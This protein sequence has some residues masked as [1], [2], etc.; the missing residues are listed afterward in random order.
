[1]DVLSEPLEA[2]QISDYCCTR[3]ILW[4]FLLSVTCTTN[5][6]II[7]GFFKRST[8]QQFEQLLRPHLSHLYK[9]A[10]RLACSTEDAED[11]IQD[12]LI[13]LYPRTE[14]LSQIESL[15][16]WLSKILYRQFV[17][18]WRKLSRVPES[19]STSE[20]Q[21]HSVYDGL[22]NGTGEPLKSLTHNQLKKNLN[23]AL[24]QLNHEQRS[25]ICMHLMDN[26]ELNDLARIFE[27]PVGTIK[28]RLHRIKT[29]L[30][31]SLIKLEPLTTPVRVKK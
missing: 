11:L 12:L 29:Q 25:L 4:N 24:K 15:R 20:D 26:H 10:L 27:V 31:M 2:R 9:I 28:S 21:L 14:E 1:M 3:Y 8:E 22:S 19:T 7:T 18:Q 13:K 16:P 17:D 5:M 30:K 23:K 6:N